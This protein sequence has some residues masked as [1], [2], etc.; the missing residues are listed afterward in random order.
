M[1]AHFRHGILTTLAANGLTPE[2]VGRW[3]LAKQAGDQFEREM[4]KEAVA[5]A[6]GKL[7]APLLALTN[8]LDA[9]DLGLTA[10]LGGS[11]GAGAIGGGLLYAA[12]R[13]DYDKR[14][15][16]FKNDQ[17]TKELELQIERI[18]RKRKLRSKLGTTPATGVQ[19]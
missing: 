19:L 8:P 11:L 18:Q 10:T 16:D 3:A 9:A 4:G 7:F 14:V 5:G 12:T 13:P 2:D 6:F 1:N 15:D 17:L